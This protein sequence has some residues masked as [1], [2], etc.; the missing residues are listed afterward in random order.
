MNCKHPLYIIDIRIFT[1]Q[2]HYKNYFILWISF[3]V[4][5]SFKYTGLLFDS[6]HFVCF[7]FIG[8]D[9]GLTSNVKSAVVKVSPLG[10]LFELCSFRFSI[11][12]LIWSHIVFSTR[13]IVIDWK[14]I[15]LESC[16]GGWRMGEKL[17]EKPTSAGQIY[18]W[19]FLKN[20]S[21]GRPKLRAWSF[22]QVCTYCRG[23][24]ACTIFCCLPRHISRKQDKLGKTRTSSTHM[25]CCCCAKCLNLLHHSASPWNLFCTE[26]W[27]KV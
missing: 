18:S 8:Y 7:P 12:R 21:R 15:V 1:G 26:C 4:L 6:I 3:N 24:R 11:Y 2:I 13:F 16:Q 25:G 22:I 23:L 19:K 14:G 9:L 17:K 20:W 10:F 27:I 5:D